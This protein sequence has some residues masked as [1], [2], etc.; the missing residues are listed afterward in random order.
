MLTL[1]RRAGARGGG[2]SVPPPN[3]F[4]LVTSTNVAISPQNF[5]NFSFN[6]FD[7]LM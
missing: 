4:F 3:S 7:T 2:K 6:P 5:L 1:F